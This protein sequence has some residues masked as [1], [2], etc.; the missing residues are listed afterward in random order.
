MRPCVACIHKM[1]RGPRQQ[2][3]DVHSQRKFDRG[4]ATGQWELLLLASAPAEGLTLELVQLKQY[5]ITCYRE[6]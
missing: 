4:E 3:Y 6:S 5:V 1:T 2:S